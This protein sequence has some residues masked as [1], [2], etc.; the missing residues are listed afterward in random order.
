MPS[1]KV[2]I[3]LMVI[4]ILFFLVMFFLFG[5]KN[6]Q[7][8][9]L[10]SVLVVGDH[11]TWTYQNRKWFYV[12]NDSAFSQLNWQKFHVFE[13]GKEK[14]DYYLWH[15]DKWYVFNNKKEAIPFDGRMVAYYGNYRVK[16]LEF[17][18]EEVE[19]YSFVHTVL[20]D[21]GLSTS[22]LFT[23]LYRVSVDFDGDSQTEDFYIMS[24][25]F[26]LEFES[27]MT[28]S[29]AFM[30][31]ENTIY[32]LYDDVSKTHGLQGC[33]PFYHSFIDTNYDGV[34]EVIVSCGKYSAEEQIDMLY[35]YQEGA[36]K[37]LIS[38]Q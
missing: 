19:D 23:S 5:V 8:D 16:L 11:T 24:N 20:E 6:I 14:G 33:K 18:E 7:Q 38:N 31:K 3:V 13:D 28:F 25:A 36:F 12:R 37:L 2:Y 27:D 10:E 32:Y 29:I 26:P 30:V 9:R 34:Y 15:D 21:H 1:K 35:S 4:M 17:Q 22:S